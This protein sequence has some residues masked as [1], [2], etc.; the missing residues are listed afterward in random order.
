VGRIQGIFTREGS[1]T[2][3]NFQLPKRSVRM[4]G[5]NTVGRGCFANSTHLV[6]TNRFGRWELGVDLLP[7]KES[8]RVHLDEASKFFE[9]LRI[10]VD[11]QANDDVVVQ[12]D[13]A[14]F[15]HNEH[16]R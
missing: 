14:V 2:T 6:R 12:P 9:G 16:R 5:V 8:P 13:A 3:P 4:R 1:L 11:L 7:W 10:V 15:L